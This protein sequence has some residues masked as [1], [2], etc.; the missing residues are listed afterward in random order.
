MTQIQMLVQEFG[1][2]QENPVGLGQEVTIPV[3]EGLNLVYASLQAL[4]SMSLTYSDFQM[5]KPQ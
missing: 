3:C 1:Q 2:V 5:N 4:Y